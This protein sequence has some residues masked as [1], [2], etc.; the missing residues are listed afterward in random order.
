MSNETE[1]DP[2]APGPSPSRRRMLLAAGGALPS[3]LTLSSGASAAA[4]SSLRCLATNQPHQRFTDVQDNWV[5]AQVPVGSY[6]SRTAYCVTSP[7]ASCLD[8]SR[9]GMPGSNWVVDGNTMTVGLGSNV[10]GQN[11]TSYG[12]VY[13]DQT[14]SITT[15]NP[16]NDGN[17]VPVTQ[18]CWTSV[19]GTR[20]TN[21]G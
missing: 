2:P 20:A 6:Q 15:L 16:G 19:I 3:V 1:K 10:Q 21:L 9:K 14:G 18:S 12:L 17:L 11:K 8:N 5:R 7:S 13:V 4:A